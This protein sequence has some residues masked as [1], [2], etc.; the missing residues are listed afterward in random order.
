MKFIYIIFYIYIFLPIKIMYFHYKKFKP[1]SKRK[2]VIYFLCSK[3]TEHFMSV[4]GATDR[5]L[6]DGH[7]TCR[8]GEGG[9]AQR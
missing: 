2:K 3:S 9:T 1:R 6:E 8:G 4:E 5:L 7:A